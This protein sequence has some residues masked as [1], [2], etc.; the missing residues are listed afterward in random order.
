MRRTHLE[1]GIGPVAQP[2]P[3]VVDGRNASLLR[4]L[5]DL[6]EGRHSLVSAS[7]GAPRPQSRLHLK[8]DLLEPQQ[9]ARG[10]DRL[11]ERGE[12]P[13]SR[14]ATA[15]GLVLAHTRLDQRCGAMQLGKLCQMSQSAQSRRVLLCSR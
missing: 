15:K 11:E 2:Q 8:V 13:G 1:R 4:P 10:H 7:A 14:V 12:P 6:G 9:P 3:R 5:S